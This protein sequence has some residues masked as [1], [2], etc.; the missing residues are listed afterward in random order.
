ML[1]LLL[2]LSRFVPFL[3]RTL[4]PKGKFSDEKSEPSE[5]RVEE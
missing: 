4:K 3:N 1:N 5:R 2:K